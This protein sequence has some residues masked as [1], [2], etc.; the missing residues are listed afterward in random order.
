MFNSQNFYNFIETIKS[1][2]KC[3]TPPK[4]LLCFDPL[5]NESPEKI[6]LVY[7]Y[8]DELRH[9]MQLTFGVDCS[10]LLYRFKNLLLR[11]IWKIE[12][13]KFIIGGKIDLI[14]EQICTFESETNKVFFGRN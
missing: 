9:F 14:S 13:S 8:F 7:E 11:S 12:N 5:T 1:L 6:R 10:N 2:L 3:V 4:N